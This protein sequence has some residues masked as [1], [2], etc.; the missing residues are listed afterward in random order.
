MKTTIL[1]L[2]ILFSLSSY[3]QT[4]HDL[5]INDLQKN[6]AK[7][8]GEEEA[9]QRFFAMNLRYPMELNYG[10]L[11]GIII[12]DQ[13]VHTIKTV[14]LNSPGK[15]FQK[16][17]ERVAQLTTDKWEKV[18]SVNT[19]YCTLTVDFS[20]I[21]NDYFIDYQNQP[22]FLSGNLVA[23][24]YASKKLKSDESLI[25][26]LNEFYA[27]K[28]YKKVENVTKELIKRNPFTES[29]YVMRIKALNEL[30]LDA[31]EEFW[32]LTEFLDKKNYINIL[33]K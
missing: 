9:I 5:N 21:S 29:I 26:S 28:D 22:K 23:K 16:E 1:F 25:E 4:F 8:I 3:S 13:K 10:T 17:F 27:Q 24:N 12:I 31:S 2:S 19:L 32:I 30:G 20:F 33:K 14:T 6:K 15:S 18:D 11:I 7:F